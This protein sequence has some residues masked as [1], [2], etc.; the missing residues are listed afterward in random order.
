MKLLDLELIRNE[1]EV[2]KICQ[3]PNII[4]L[5]DV[6]ENLNYIYIIMEYC[7]GGDLFTFLANKKFK[8]S[9]EMACEIIHKLAT[10]I[11]YIHS[12]GIVHRDL[13]PENIMMIEHKEDKNI[14]DL[15]LVD[16]GLSK[17][18]GPTEYCNE[19]FG[20]IVKY[21]ININYLNI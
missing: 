19:P 7:N 10:A 15:R 9:E 20:T 2:L 21:I 6:I 8:I 14:I 4:R 18:I 16:F 5:Y 13:K 3:H 11:F 1:I 12:Y 17:I